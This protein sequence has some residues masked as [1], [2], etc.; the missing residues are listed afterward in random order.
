M[1]KPIVKIHD[2]ETGEI[3]EREM[4]DEEFTQYELDRIAHEAQIKALT[5]IV[6]DEPAAKS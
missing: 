5:E 6:S 4:N 2:V 1:T 3:I